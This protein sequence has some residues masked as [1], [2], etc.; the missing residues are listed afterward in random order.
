MFNADRPEAQEEGGN[1]GEVMKE[2]PGAELQAGGRLWST[3]LTAL[4]ARKEDD[5]KVT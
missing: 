2:K 1:S 3:L 5:G 4:R